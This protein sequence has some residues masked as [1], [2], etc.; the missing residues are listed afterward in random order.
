MAGRPSTYLAEFR[1]EAIESVHSSRRCRVDVA[2]SLGISDKTLAN[3]MRA[4]QERRERDAVPEAL[5]ESERVKRRRL[6]RENVVLQMAMEIL[7]KA[8]AYFAV[9]TTR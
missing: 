7:R 2:R 9:E 6:C 5:T 3:L 1:R 8:A 4:D